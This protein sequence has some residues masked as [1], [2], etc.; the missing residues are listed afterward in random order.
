M[1][2]QSLR[3]RAWNAMPKHQRMAKLGLHRGA[4]MFEAHRKLP[5]PL[6]KGHRIHPDGSVGPRAKRPAPA[7]LSEKGPGD[8]PKQ[9]G[10]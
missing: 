6:P 2:D 3:I 8:S 9:K 5:F 7:F 10:L 1:K 4:D